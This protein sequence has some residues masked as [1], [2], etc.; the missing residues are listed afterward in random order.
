MTDTNHRVIWEPTRPDLTIKVLTSTS[1]NR[2]YHETLFEVVSRHELNDEKLAHLDAAGLLGFG[3]CYSVRRH[4]TLTESAPPVTVDQR[5]GQVL[6]DVPPM[7]HF[8]TPIT[9][10]HD[11]LY[12]RYEVL[13]ICDSG[14]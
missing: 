2:G 10:T 5:T 6:A 13:R 7:S 3:Q 14:D 11:Y 4:E 8:G 1:T 12:H 9:D